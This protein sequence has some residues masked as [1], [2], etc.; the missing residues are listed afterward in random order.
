MVNG[1]VPS[2]QVTSV[3][4]PSETLKLRVNTGGLAFLVEMKNNFMEESVSGPSIVVRYILSL[5]YSFTY[6]CYCMY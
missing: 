1:L 6:C 3:G 2:V 5:Y 4:G